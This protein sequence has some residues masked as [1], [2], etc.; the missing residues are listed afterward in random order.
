[1]HA[2]PNGVELARCLFSN[3]QPPFGTLDPF[4]SSFSYVRRLG[5]FPLPTMWLCCA[6]HHLTVGVEAHMHQFQPG[7]CALIAAERYSRTLIMYYS[8]LLHALGGAHDR[9]TAPSLCAP[10]DDARAGRSNAAAHAWI[11]AWAFE[12][13]VLKN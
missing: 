6:G 12:R 13:L 5:S 9:C 4:G 7:A 8:R 3:N 2:L 11:L 1:M 10:G